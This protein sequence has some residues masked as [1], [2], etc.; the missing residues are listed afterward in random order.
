MKHKHFR[1]V[2]AIEHDGLV[3][4]DTTN[5][6]EWA[7][8]IIK[9]LV[10]DGTVVKDKDCFLTPYYIKTDTGRIDTV[11]PFREKAKIRMRLLVGWKEFV[12]NAMWVYDYITKYKK[13]HT[14]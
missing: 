9:M 7:H 4:V 10:D 11:I 5:P 6:E 1:D 3:I 14:K 12:P 8:G 2:E 13:E